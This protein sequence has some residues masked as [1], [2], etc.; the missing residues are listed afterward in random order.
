LDE[1]AWEIQE[2]DEADSP[3]YLTAFQ[4]ARAASAV[5]FAVDPDGVAARESI[6]EAQVALGSIDEARRLIDA[7]LTRE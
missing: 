6:Y 3:L 4:R 7:L 1:E 2:S 5:A